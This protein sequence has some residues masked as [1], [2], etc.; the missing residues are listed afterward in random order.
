MI[1]KGHEN[2]SDAVEVGK[3]IT[4]VKVGDRVWVEAVEPCYQCE[5]GLQ[6]GYKAN[7]FK[8][9]SVKAGGINGLHG[10]F[11]FSYFGLSWTVLTWYKMK[12][13]A[14]PD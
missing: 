7:Y 11:A 13:I 6:E 12:H 9:W 3:S 2:A 14:S 5:W 8:C 4:E 10:G 1:A